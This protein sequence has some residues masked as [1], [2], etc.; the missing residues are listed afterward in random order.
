[1]LNIFK[2]NIFKVKAGEIYFN[3][4][5]KKYFI[6]DLATEELGLEPRTVFSTS[7]NKKNYFF[8]TGATTSNDFAKVIN[9][10]WDLDHINLSYVNSNCPKDIHHIPYRHYKGDVY[11]V[12]MTA[13]DLTIDEPAYIYFNPAKPNK[14][15]VRRAT[16]FQADVYESHPRFKKLY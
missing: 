5:C 10:K 15:W 16:D 13:F 14:T 3:S 8:I 12:A 4:H 6:H 11:I 1:M 7:I 2:K 9:T